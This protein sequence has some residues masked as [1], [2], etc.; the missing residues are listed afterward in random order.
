MKSHQFGKCTH[1]IFLYI[2]EYNS[3]SCKPHDSTTPHPKNMGVETPRI[4]ANDCIYPPL[5]P[6]QSRVSY[7]ILPLLIF[8]SVL[9]SMLVL[10]W[11]YP[12]STQ[13]ALILCFSLI[14]NPH[15]IFPLPHTA[16]KIYLHVQITN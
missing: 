16:S 8:P 7:V 9:P 11:K 1:L 6:I 2:I 12:L 5:P 13:S 15:E 4:D 3:I 14:K 10:N